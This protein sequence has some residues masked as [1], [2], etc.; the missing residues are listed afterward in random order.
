MTTTAAT[1]HRVVDSQARNAR[2]HSKP[3]AFADTYLVDG[4]HI[5]YGPRPI[6]VTYT[7]SETGQALSKEIWH[8]GKALRL[9]S[10]LLDHL[11]E[12]QPDDTGA[13]ALALAVYELVESDL[14]TGT[15]IQ[16]WPSWHALVDQVLTD[17]TS[18][19]DRNA[20]ITTEWSEF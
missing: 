15:S 8:H 12:H 3:S 20:T 4:W 5:P 2:E 11:V 10:D 14:I 17:A 16:A 6:V 18:L 13:H 7:D 9:V 19:Q 1:T